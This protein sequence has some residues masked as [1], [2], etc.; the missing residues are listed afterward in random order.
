MTIKRIL[1]NIF[2]NSQNLPSFSACSDCNHLKTQKMI[3]SHIKDDCIYHK[4]WYEPVDNDSREPKHIQ[5][6]RCTFG[7]LATGGCNTDCTS[8]TP[9]NRWNTCNKGNKYC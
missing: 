7:L 2:W 3:K 9:Y 4:Y 5:I 1:S 8:Y 6:D